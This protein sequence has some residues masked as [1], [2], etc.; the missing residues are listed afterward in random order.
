MGVSHPQ[1]VGVRSSRRHALQYLSYFTLR[2]ED[3]K[4]AVVSAHFASLCSESEKAGTDEEWAGGDESDELKH[5]G[6]RSSSDGDLV[7]PAL[8]LTTW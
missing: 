7:F 6:T 8:N 3:L 2:W 1:N 5:D 4:D